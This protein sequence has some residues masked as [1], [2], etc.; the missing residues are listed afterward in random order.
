MLHHGRQSAFNTCDGG[1]V[2]AP[3]SGGCGLQHRR[4]HRSFREGSKLT[5]QAD[6]RFGLNAKVEKECHHCRQGILRGIPVRFAGIVTQLDTCL[7][8]LLELRHLFAQPAQGRQLMW[9]V[10]HNPILSGSE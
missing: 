8:S 4:G 5:Q 9:F 1:R 6:Q 7:P 2:L 3:M 10:G